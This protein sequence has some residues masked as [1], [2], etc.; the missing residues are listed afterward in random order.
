MPLCRG[1]GAKEEP[2]GEPETGQGEAGRE[3][4]EGVLEAQGRNVFREGGSD[5]LRYCCG[6]RKVTAQNDMVIHAH[7]STRELGG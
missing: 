2:S 1:W 6:S 7:A 4:E 5:Q 3:A